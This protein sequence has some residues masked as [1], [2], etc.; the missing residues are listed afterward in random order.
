MFL[1][2]THERDYRVI[3]QDNLFGIGVNHQDPMKQTILSGVT[4][5]NG[6]P[7]AWITEQITETIH[8]VTVGDNFQT[9]ALD[10]IVTAVDEKVLEF[11]SGEQRFSMTIGDSFAYARAVATDPDRNRDVSQAENT[12]VIAESLD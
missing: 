8:R 9:D 7:T 5:R 3:A 1:V 10:G 12:S 4:S 2:S 11:E 6:L